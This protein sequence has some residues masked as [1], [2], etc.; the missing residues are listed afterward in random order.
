MNAN[1]YGKEVCGLE[2]CT[3]PDTSRKID[4]CCHCGAHFVPSYQCAD[5]PHGKFVPKN[6]NDRRINSGIKKLREAFSLK[7]WATTDV[8]EKLWDEGVK[9]IRTKK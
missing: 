5:V 9:I 1:E 7:G 6:L 3:H 8:C 4:V 2:H